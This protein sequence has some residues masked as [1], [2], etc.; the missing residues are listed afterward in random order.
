M[1]KVLGKFELN[2]RR[3]RRNEA[4]D[5]KKMFQAGYSMCGSPEAG[6][7]LERTKNVPQFTHLA[8]SQKASMAKECSKQGKVAQIK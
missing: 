2:T 8:P 3:L 4:D 5:K 1:T 6:E 7:R